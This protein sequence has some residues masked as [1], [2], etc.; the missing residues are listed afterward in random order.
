MLDKCSQTSG[1][2]LASGVELKT[3]WEV[4]AESGYNN[5]KNWT[6]AGNLIAVRTIKG[7]GLLILSESGKIALEENTLIVV[8]QHKLKQYYC[9]EERWNFWWF[10][11][12]IHGTLPFPLLHLLEIPSHY[13]D[14]DDLNQ[15]QLLLT[16]TDFIQRALASSIFGTMLYRW[17]AA[18]NGEHRRKPH[19][20]AIEAVIAEMHKRLAGFTLGEMSKMAFLSE[21]RFRQVFLELTGKS[22][23][24]YYDQV[25]L[26]MGEALLQQGI[27]NVGE[28][29]DQLGF[30]SPFHFSHAFSRHFGYPPSKVGQSNYITASLRKTTEAQ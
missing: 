29:A 3:I 17:I 18:W 7:A 5:R 27:C 13:H 22:P 20:E 24:I 9:T 16:R 6:S 30:S 2:S 19:Q 8:E 26:Q 12:N 28:A 14:K 4:N 23:K 10:E 1:V 11:F 25:R 15:C 21:R